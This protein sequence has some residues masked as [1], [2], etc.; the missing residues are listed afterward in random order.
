MSKYILVFVIVVALL[1]SCKENPSNNENEEDLP[2]V[3]T[4]SISNITKTSAQCGGNVVDDGG[5]N[6]SS[7]GVCWSTSST[8]DINDDCTFDSTGLGLFTSD[9]SD[10]AANTRYYVR[11]YATNDIGTGYG[12]IN[13]FKTL[14]DTVLDI[15]GNVYNSIEIGDQIWMIENLKVTH[16]RNGDPI[17]NVTDSTTW[18]GL[19]SGAYS[20]YNNN[21]SF[22][23]TY[24]R[25]YNWFATSDSRGIAP[26]GWHV[27]T[28]E[29]W[30]NLISYLGGNSDAAGKVKEEGTEHWNSPNEGATNETG[31]NA[32]PAGYRDYGGSFTGMGNVTYF[33]T[34]SNYSPLN[35]WA[36]HIH[37]DSAE[38][39]RDWSHKALG[40]SVRC[41]KDSQ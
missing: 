29:D 4:S 35:A 3:Q 24:G 40:F 7:R 27:A 23:E 34:S 5:F 21:E 33:W 38:L 6:I 20:S 25:I 9:I 18:A 19:S 10:L 41:V 17:P 32:L 1:L 30:Q 37:Y 28:D 11:A 2:I 13:T 22:V 8:P 31:F 16:Y 26:E 39:F 14:L 36:Y 12:E 15:D